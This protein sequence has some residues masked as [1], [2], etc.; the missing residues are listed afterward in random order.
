MD[1]MATTQDW[2]DNVSAERT[3]ED[4]Q[5]WQMDEPAGCQDRPLSPFAASLYQAVREGAAAR[6]AAQA[7]AGIE[8]VSCHL[9]WQAGYELRRAEVERRDRQFGEDLDA[10][11]RGYHQ[12]RAATIAPDRHP[13]IVALDA[14]AYAH[15]TGSG[16]GVMQ[17]DGIR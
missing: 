3:A 13:C 4:V 7:L 2:R 17:E 10:S 5:P 12:R 8:A 16:E 11:E 6:A 15:A 9:I 1:P 14:R